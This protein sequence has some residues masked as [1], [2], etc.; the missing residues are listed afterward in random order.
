MQ[1]QEDQAKGSSQHLKLVKPRNS[2]MGTTAD[3][4][5]A[6]GAFEDIERRLICE[7][8]T[9]IRFECMRWNNTKPP[10]SGCGEGSRDEGCGDE[11]LK[12]SVEIRASRTPQNL[13]EFIRI[14]SSTKGS[15]MPST[16]EPLQFTIRRSLSVVP[17]PEGLPS[18]PPI[19]IKNLVISAILDLV[20]H[21]L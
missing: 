3:R 9:L 15:H 11:G 10:G 14:I 6:E 5:M 16:R 7:G 17:P 18:P 1:Q 4:E 19:K 12:P 20:M 2:K 21:T 8:S 13:V